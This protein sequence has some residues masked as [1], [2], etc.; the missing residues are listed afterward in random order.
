MTG[1]ESSETLLF[2]KPLPFS[3]RSLK[4]LSLNWSFCI[5]QTST[6]LV[7]SF[8]WFQFL[9]T[10]MALSCLRGKLIALFQIGRELPML[11]MMVCWSST[12]VPHPSGRIFILPSTAYWLYVKKREV[13]SYIYQACCN[14]Q[15]FKFL[16]VR[17]LV[18]WRTCDAV[19]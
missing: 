15:L 8:E 6:F 4:A 3:M 18:H 5:R 13:A 1:P 7:Q 10:K 19:R 11:C 14:A 17:Y 2:C 9:R 12:C 16:M